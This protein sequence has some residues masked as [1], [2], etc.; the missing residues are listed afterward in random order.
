MTISPLLRRS[1]ERVAREG[2]EGFMGGHRIVV[3]AGPTGLCPCCAAHPRAL[4]LAV[5]GWRWKSFT[6]WITRPIF[7]PLRHRMRATFRIA[8]R[9]RIWPTTAT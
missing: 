5:M 4:V 9:T 1:T 2:Y 7:T 3:P 6:A 8:S